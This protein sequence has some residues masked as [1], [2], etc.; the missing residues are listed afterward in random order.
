MDTQAIRLKLKIIPLPIRIW[1]ASEEVSS[2]IDTINQRFNIQEKDRVVLP[3]LL[4]RLEAKDL[5]PEYFT[6]EL[7]SALTI[8]KNKALGISAEIKRLILDPVKNDFGNIGVDISLLDKFQ[9]PIIKPPALNVS[10]N[11]NL[12]INSNQTDVMTPKPAI[13]SDIGWSKQPQTTPTAPA[14]ITKTATPPPVPTPTPI[15]VPVPKPIAPAPAPEPAPVMLHQ[16]TAFKPAEKNVGFT[17]TKP[18]S[19]A[20]MSFGKSPAQTPIRPAVLEFGSSTGGANKPTPKPSVPEFKSA[21]I[22]A[23]T[24]SGG[25]RNISQITAPTASPVP[26]PSPISA[27]P[28]PPAPPTPPKPSVI[29]NFTGG[30][31]PT[32][33]PVPRPPKTSVSPQMPIPQPPQPPKPPASPF[34]SIPKP[35]APPTPPQNNKAIVKDFLS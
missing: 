21:P 28:K 15:S 3:T 7:S 18:Q 1:F 34:A 30:S 31:I 27:V 20:E 16:D 4:V 12:K 13:L 17:L 19:G 8:D 14:A 22:T 33:P 35:P 11:E 24:A 2:I 26:P 29:K 5:G 23:P 9:V 6:G 25:S 32:P 10:T